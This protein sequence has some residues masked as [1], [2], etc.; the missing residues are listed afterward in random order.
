MVALVVFDPGWWLDLRK[1]FLKEQTFVKQTG[2]ISQHCNI[3]KSSEIIESD[4]RVIL[5]VV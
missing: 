1:L 4:R 3:S 5:T 2:S